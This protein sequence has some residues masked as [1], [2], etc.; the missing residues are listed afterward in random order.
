MSPHPLPPEALVKG[1]AEVWRTL[2]GGR[3]EERICAAGRLV[4]WHGDQGESLALPDR[5][6]GLLD[7]AGA[8][9]SADVIPSGVVVNLPPGVSVV[10]AQPH[11]LGHHLVAESISDA[12]DCLRRVG[13][14]GIDKARRMGCRADVIGDDEYLGLA[15]LKAEALGGR[16]PHPGLVEALRST[17]GN[18]RVSLRGVRFEGEAV[19]AVLTVRIDGYGMLVDGASDRGHWDKNPNNLAVWDALSTLIGGGARHIDY[20]FSPVGA[21]DARFKDHMGGRAVSLYQV[22]GA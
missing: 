7:P 15:R 16:A 18:E 13:R 14:Q 2:A 21:G 17:Y 8:E 12:W 19:A 5:M 1:F 22:T 3:I 9:V 6:Y 4:I 10:G 20:G 11:C